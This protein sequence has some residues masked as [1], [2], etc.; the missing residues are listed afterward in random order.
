MFIPRA[1]RRPASA[2]GRRGMSR[3]RCRRASPNSANAIDRPISLAAR[4]MLKPWAASARKRSRSRLVVIADFP[5]CDAAPAAAYTDAPRRSKRKSTAGKAEKAIC[6]RLSTGAEPAARSEALSQRRAR[7]G[8]RDGTPKGPEVTP[9]QTWPVRSGSV[10]LM[11]VVGLVTGGVRAGADV[12]LAGSRREARRGARPIHP[13]RLLS[14]TV[15]TL[16]PSLQ[17]SLRSGKSTLPGSG[18]D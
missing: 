15:P 16:R 6:G 8:F 4:D 10:C 9:S 13:C 12:S 17:R 3:T 2:C 11:R 18:A 1:W 5:A 7:A 14:V